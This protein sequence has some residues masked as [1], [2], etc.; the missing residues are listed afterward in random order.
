ME[1]LRVSEEP[2]HS[3]DSSLGKSLECTSVHG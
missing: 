1:G 2:F 3:A